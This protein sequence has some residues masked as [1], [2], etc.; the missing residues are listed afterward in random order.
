MK[1]VP[2]T[3]TKPTTQEQHPWRATA[4]TLFAALIPFPSMWAL[5]AEA[6]GLDTSWTWLAVSLA[7]TAGITRVMALPAVNAF[8][9]RFLPW[10]LPAPR[11]RS[12]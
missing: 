8:L 6:L 4:R 7:V 2:V 3:T 1:G 9:A 11:D 5:I 12:E 10:L